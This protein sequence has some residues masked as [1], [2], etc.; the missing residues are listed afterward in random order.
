MAPFS[1]KS[2]MGRLLQPMK[3]AR[4]PCGNRAL[5][6]VP[7]SAGEP[8]FRNH[9]IQAIGREREKLTIETPPKLDF[10]HFSNSSFKINSFTFPV[11]SLILL[12]FCP[13]CAKS[14]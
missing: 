3:K 11:K 10:A 7:K 1:S 12:V 9:G 6:A 8:V 14:S 13:K 2:D 5:R 4:I